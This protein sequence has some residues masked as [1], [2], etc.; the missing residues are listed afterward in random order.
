MCMSLD[1]KINTVTGINPVNHF[2]PFYP[3]SETYRFYCL[4]PDDFTRQ[5]ELLRGERVLSVHKDKPIRHAYQDH[6]ELMVIN[7]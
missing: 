5:W 3:K 4:M 7:Q 1:L 2:N 6:V